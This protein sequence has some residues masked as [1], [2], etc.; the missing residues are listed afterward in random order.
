[1]LPGRSKSKTARVCC[2]ATRI[3]FTEKLREPNFVCFFILNL[4]KILKSEIEICLCTNAFASIVI[5][6]WLFL[7]II[8]KSGV[9][10][11]IIKFISVAGS[12]ATTILATGSGAA[13]RVGWDFETTALK[14]LIGS[15]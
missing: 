6:L 12:Q 13:T 5:M 3:E 2:L 7:R 4:F 1:M 9:S 8:M 14:P 10:V 11:Y 15:A